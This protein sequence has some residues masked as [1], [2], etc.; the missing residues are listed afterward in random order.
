M[1]VYIYIYASKC[2]YIYIYTPKCV[3][4]YI[5]ILLLLQIVNTYLHMQMYT[6]VIY[7]VLTPY[8]DI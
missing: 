5:Y 1:R 8:R 6:Y 2:V 4:I 7:V 3:Y